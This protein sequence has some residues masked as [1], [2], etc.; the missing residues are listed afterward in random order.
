VENRFLQRTKSKLTKAETTA[1]YRK[2]SA[3]A[4]PTES[5]IGK[6]NEGMFKALNAMNN[7]KDV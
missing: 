1:E 3:H 5:G 2:A 7:S 4:L 6:V